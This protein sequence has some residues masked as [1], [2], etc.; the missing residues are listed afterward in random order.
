[1]FRTDIRFAL[2]AGCVL[3]AACSGEPHGTPTRVIIPRG[4]SFGQATDSLAKAKLVGWP[5]VF[6]MYGRLTGGD[7]NIKPGTYLF[8]PGTPWS[9][10]VSA[11]N[12]GHG[13]VNTI[14]IPE[15]WDLSQITPQLARTLKVPADSVRAAMRDTALLARLDIPNPTL[16][17]YVFPD[18]YAFP[19][20]TTARQAVREMVFAF[21]RR[22]KPDWDSSLTDLKINRNDLVTMASIV[23]REARVPEERP[24]IAAVY[25]NRLRRG[26]LLQADPTIQY[27]LGHHVGRV[28]YKD[29]AVASPYNTYIHKGPP[30]GPIASPG[31]ASLAAAAHPASVPYLYFVASRD[32]HHEFRMTLE[33]H[34]SAIRQVRATLPPRKTKPLML[35]SAETNTTAQSTSPAAAKP[36]SKTASKTSAKTTASKTP[37]KTTGKVAPKPTSNLTATSASK[38]TVKPTTKTTVKSTSKT[39]AKPAPKK[40][41][42]RTATTKKRVPAHTVFLA[43]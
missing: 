40:S 16:E 33:E 19:L 12:G 9:D 39:T 1:M 24:V 3:I 29:L 32:G 5:K 26:M 42:K 18:T 30:P 20:G 34:A 22:W 38:T 13:L 15:G 14:T 23:E 4:A 28:L 27:A 25:Y 6:R 41:T 37:A 8:K 17:G 11:L 21:E 43:R 10:I 2:V 7:R 35:A 36:V 31:V